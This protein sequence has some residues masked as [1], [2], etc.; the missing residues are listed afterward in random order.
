[1]NVSI[2]FVTL[3][4]FAEAQTAKYIIED[5]DPRTVTF[6]TYGG[7]SL[8]RAMSILPL[9]NK[10][11]LVI[12][13][14]FDTGSGDPTISKVRKKDLSV[15]WTKVIKLK[16]YDFLYSGSPT[17][18][19]NYVASGFTNSSGAGSLDCW[20]VK[21]NPSGDTLWTRTFGGPKDERGYEITA[22]SHYSY[23][24]AATTTSWGSGDIDGLIIKVNASGDILWHKVIGEKLIDRTYSIVE[25]ENGDLVI[26]GIT[27]ANYPGNSDILLYRLT[28]DG[29][30][31]WRKVMGGAKG[32]IAHCLLKRPDNTLM[33]IGYTAEKGDSLSYPL[34]IHLNTSG[35]LIEK[36]EVEPG[37][38]IKLID[39]YINEQGDCIGTGFM[40]ASLKS[41]FDIVLF[42]LEFAK[43]K[44]T[45]KRLPVSANAEEAYGS[46]T[47]SKSNALIVG[48]SMATRKGDMLFIKWTY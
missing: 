48:H 39:G 25:V 9:D 34:I 11:D 24:V 42:K 43:K 6:K 20:I 13:L 2:C 36:F 37:I 15:E 31:V 32:D 45:I 33:M 47:L 16:G 44:L 21:F 40:R 14:N 5:V 7:D 28:K 35:E 30:T 38:D 27:N 41:P 19:G 23:V 10:S 46:A 12:G 22:T 8:D 29:D 3:V 26:S 1:M 17:P 4:S 18:D